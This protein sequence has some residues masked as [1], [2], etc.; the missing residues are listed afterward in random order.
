M[1]A[2]HVRDLL[3]APTLVP[4]GVTSLLAPYGFRDPVSADRNLQAIATDPMTRGLLAEILPELLRC[5]AD[6]VDP[7]AALNHFE[8]F[9]KA[10]GGPQALLGHLKADP[11]SI[12]V[13]ARAFGASSFMAEILVRH[14]AWF[15]WLTDPEV[16]GHARDRTEIERDLDGALGTL[17]TEVRQRDLLRITRRREILH[18]GVRDL[19]RLAS[20]DETLAALS[21][22]A[23]ALIRKA[24][25][26]AEAALFA[27]YGI[28]PARGRGPGERRARSGFAV[29]GMG[30]LGGNEL[31]F[32]SDVDLVYVYGSDRGPAERASSGIAWP[33]FYES[34]AQRLTAALSELSPE[35]Y[36]YR[37]DLRLRPEGRV[38]PLAQSL[39]AC[40]EYY[41]ERGATWERLALLRAWPVA[42]DSV[43]GRRFL[44]LVRSFI[45][46]RPF[47]ADEVAA[48]KRLK[49]DSDRRIAGRDETHRNVKLG[50]GGIREIEFIAQ[51]LQV[52]HGGR[53]PRLQV[54]NTRAAL[55][56]LKARR[57]LGDDEHAVLTTSYVFLRDLENKLQMVADAQTH[58]L[59]TSPEALR[60]CGRSL[61]YRGDAELDPGEA[62]MKDY[63][64]HT[65]AT[66]RV[67]EAVFDG[68]RLTSPSA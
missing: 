8:R 48:M 31:N 4:A 5:L 44:A 25:E 61:G 42:G 66:H 24:T 11:R 50:F 7:D 47:A 57:L 33:E 6:S 20:V 36:V 1:A 29:V 51:A 21:D 34:L 12:E 16:L 54:R 37:V 62:L 18:I 15:Y 17:H 67:F 60:M 14:P 35:G 27:E 64:A 53:Y 22:L 68:G 59:P 26:G 19:L 30:K 52:R 10:T 55:D 65:A 56:A 49:H 28:S 43:V 3:L 41:D 13:L 39:A 38:G 40:G 9:V 2:A 45:Y 32:S 58:A 63:R 23:G 46:D